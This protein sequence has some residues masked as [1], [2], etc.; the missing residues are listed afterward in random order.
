[1]DYSTNSQ[2]KLAYEFVENTGENI[3]LTGKAGTGKTTFLHQIRKNSMKRSIVVAPTGVAA[4]NAGG[5]TIHSFFQLP[6]GP[7]LPEN[8]QTQQTVDDKKRFLKL[9][10]EKINII[11]SLDLLI[12][13]EVSM[14]RADLLDGIDRVLRRYRQRD[15]PFGGIQL[16]L[17]GDLQQLPPVVREEERALLS[18]HYHSFFFFGSHALAQAR[19][20]SIELKKIYR[21]SDENF[22]R[23]LN[24]V[25]DNQLDHQSLQALNARYRH[26]V[27]ESEK[28]GYITLTTHNH[29]AR[30][31][32]QARLEGLNNV[33]RHFTAHIDGEFPEMAWPTEQ[34][35]TLKTGA[36]V[37]FVKNDPSP[38]KLFY[39][40]KIGKVVGVDDENIYV[41]CPDDHEEIAVKPLTWENTKYKLDPQSKE[42]KE[43]VVGTFT[44]FP[45]K[46]AWAITIHKSQGLTFEKAIIDANAAFA[47]GQVYVALSRCKNMDGLI[48]SSKIIPQALR[49]DDDILDFSR[50]VEQNQPNEKMLS[51]ARLQFQHE[52]LNELFDFSGILKNLYYFRKIA[53][54]KTTS[55]DENAPAL[56]NQIIQS[57]KNDL[58]DVSA[59]FSRE[60]NKH[61]MSYNDVERNFALQDRIKK[62]CG[63]FKPKLEE[64]INDRLNKIDTNVDNRA[65]QKNL[66]ENINKIQQEIN[67]KIACLENCSRGFKTADYLETRAKAS[68]ETDKKTSRSGKGKVTSESMVSENPLLLKE[69]REWRDKVAEQLNIPIFQ[70]LPRKS[71]ITISNIL[72]ATPAALQAIHGLG[73]KKVEQYGKDIISLV[74]DYCTNND[75]TPSYGEELEMLKKTTKNEK[76]PTAQIT[77]E[78]FKAGKNIQQVAEERGLAISTI[79]G[80]L[81]KYIQTGEIAAEKLVQPEKIDAVHALLKQDPSKNLSDLRQNL[82][83]QYSWTEIKAAQAYFM[84][85]NKLEP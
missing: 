28:D 83:N 55:L 19:F 64:E 51:E 17:I 29:Q 13:D 25:R 56:I 58:E 69:L 48:L 45:L 65:L 6:F 21:Q 26:N 11:K 30:R 12:V 80:H 36:Q 37:M 10:K 40:G 77:M 3:F 72:P 35:L 60:V 31:I 67:L 5:V 4:I 70:I 43:N 85:L 8:T 50:E 41:K 2:L 27:T 62:A 16:L 78:L 54:E 34:K 14:V 53:N 59:K 46:L 82:G 15:K 63:Y 7:I 61:I 32:N 18:Q 75:L 74:M 57:L 20:I 79:E 42:I 38:E 22:I 73:K 66:N 1:M 68:I 24:K 84:Y 23:L 44:Q 9:N 76:K 52:L 49:N 81:T 39:N 47:H 33:K 71:M